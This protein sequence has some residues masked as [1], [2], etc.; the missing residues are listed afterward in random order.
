MRALRVI[1]GK[2]ERRG[3]RRGR[4]WYDPPP[5]HAFVLAVATVAFWAGL[6]I[7]VLR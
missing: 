6:L 1:Q 7:G 3:R 4:R 5:D 2:P